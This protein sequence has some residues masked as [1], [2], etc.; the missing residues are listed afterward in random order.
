MDKLAAAAIDSEK[1]GM[2]KDSLASSHF[3]Y[4]GTIAFYLNF[5]Q[6]DSLSQMITGSIPLTH[7]N[8]SILKAT[9]SNDANDLGIIDERLGIVHS[10]VKLAQTA[11]MS[12]TCDIS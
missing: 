6:T 5:H 10:S 2:L 1:C 12:W 7:T 11:G 3:Q 8:K 4:L 9:S